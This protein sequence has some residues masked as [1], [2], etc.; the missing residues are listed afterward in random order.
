MMSESH[1]PT[2]QGVYAIGGP[3]SQNLRQF[4]PRLRPDH[5]SQAQLSAWKAPSF[6]E[7]FGAALF[8]PQNR[9]IV[10]FCL[11]FIFPFGNST[12]IISLRASY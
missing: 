6:D 4:T 8:S 2:E 5:R 11:G 3:Q 7:N 1:S 9:Q 12:P 10:F